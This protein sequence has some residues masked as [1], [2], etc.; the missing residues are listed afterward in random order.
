M[1][2]VVKLV[3]SMNVEVKMPDDF[4][5]TDQGNKDQFLDEVDNALEQVNIPPDI[6]NW[7]IHSVE[8]ANPDEMTVD[9]EADL[10]LLID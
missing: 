7:T 5:P 4:D 3:K 8:A 9:Q 10:C 2:L 6:G 1:K